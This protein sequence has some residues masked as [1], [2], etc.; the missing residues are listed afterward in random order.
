MRY[1]HAAHLLRN[2][3]L[4]RVVFAETASSTPLQ[5]RD[6]IGM[7]AMDALPSIPREVGSYELRLGCTIEHFRECHWTDPE[8]SRRVALEPTQRGTIHVVRDLVQ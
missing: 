1:E 3:A 7:N 5:D 6:S 2:C 4:P 8:S